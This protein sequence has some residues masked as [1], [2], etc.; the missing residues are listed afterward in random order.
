M[1]PETTL[2][3][4]LKP[5]DL[6]QFV[7]SHRPRLEAGDYRVSAT[8]NLKIEATDNLKPLRFDSAAL[9]FSVLGDRLALDDENFHA[10]FPPPGSRGKFGQVLPHVALS[11]S[12]LPWERSPLGG[13]VEDPDSPS[14]LALLVFTEDEAKQ[15]SAQLV[16]ANQ[17]QPHPDTSETTAKATPFFQKDFTLESGQQPSD[18]VSVIDVPWGL[19]KTIL[20]RYQ[21]LGVTAHV[22]RVG[23]AAGQSATDAGLHV[24]PA[25]PAVKDPEDPATQEASFAS[26]AKKGWDP[27]SPELA[28]I[29]GNRLPTAGKHGVV[30]LVSLEERYQYPDNLTEAPDPCLLRP[31]LQCA[32]EQLATWLQAGQKQQVIQENELLSWP[33]GKDA[34]GPAKQGK[35]QVIVATAWELRLVAD[36]RPTLWRIAGEDAEQVAMLQPARLNATD[37]AKMCESMLGDE[38]SVWRT[39]LQR[40]GKVRFSASFSR[41]EDSLGRIDVRIFEK[42]KGFEPLT[43]AQIQDLGNQAPLEQGLMESGL[44][45]VF[46][47]LTTN[48]LSADR[49]RR[50]CHW[51][52]VQ[53]RKRL[54]AERTNLLTSES[55]STAE[56]LAEMTLAN[57]LRSRQDLADNAYVDGKDSGRPIKGW[58]GKEPMFEIKTRAF[59]VGVTLALDAQDSGVRATLSHRVRLRAG[60]FRML[61]PEPIFDACGATDE[62]RVRL[63]S[64]KSWPFECLAEG[65]GFYEELSRL[66]HSNSAVAEFQV[67]LPEGLSE[68]TAFEHQVALEEGRR[69]LASG[70]VAL[71]HGLRGGD[72][73]FSWYHGPFLSSARA[74]ARLKLPA[75][76]SDEL[77][78]YNETLGMFDVSYAA[79]WELGRLTMLEDSYHAMK[80]FHWKRDHSRTLAHLRQKL[81]YDFLP[82]VRQTADLA[83]PDSLATWFRSLT[84]LED[85]P[86]NYLVPDEQ[87]LPPES[88]RFFSVDS[89]WQECLRDGAFSVG[90]VLHKDHLEDSSHSLNL[91]PAPRL[92]GFLLRS[93]VVSDWPQLVVNGYTAI[94]RADAALEAEPNPQYPKLTLERFDRLGPN[95]LICLFSD[96]DRKGREL[97]MV[98]IHLPAEVLHFGLEEDSRGTLMK[99]FRDASTGENLRQWSWPGPADQPGD[100]MGGYKIDSITLES[101]EIAG[102]HPEV[103]KKIKAIENLTFE[104]SAKDFVQHH[105]KRGSGGHGAG[106]EQDELDAQLGNDPAVKVQDL[107]LRNSGPFQINNQTIDKI[108]FRLN[109]NHAENVIDLSALFDEVANRLAPIFAQHYRFTAADFSLQML[110]L[111]P[112]VR[113]VR[114]IKSEVT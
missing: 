114:P 103:L 50:L 79:A 37:V 93:K 24:L 40:A 68:E 21:D 11:R 48:P 19:L 38:Q 89:M 52:N 14:W 96:P 98:D 26:A 32:N 61:K 15:V 76:G 43:N 86:F 113:Y 94:D 78:I 10:V 57:L 12:T 33:S 67:P 70:A 23:R 39:Q 100:G 77:L 109:G 30:H 92:S 51:I 105:L 87:L 29:I 95:V 64:L 91:D 63:V 58:L 55:P 27:V 73:T 104:G 31:P 59:S 65:G 7:E 106:L 75:R 41:G 54:L 6:V 110:D 81:D 1:K 44:R 108:P 13:T 45:L 35:N 83:L 49:A 46:L 85:A 8:Q 88:I 42:G 34:E 3:P 4:E 20:P 84:L 112:L 53:A 17:L 16:T 5:D 47:D 90:R 80:L 22:R 102:V 82:L 9:D 69:Y 111:P 74:Q 36:E 97:E 101:L 60:T 56:D 99:Q 72:R 25:I 2:P 28:L 71:R 62:A 66:N 18:R 107:I